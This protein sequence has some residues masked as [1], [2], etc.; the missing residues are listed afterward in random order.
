M[1]P[2]STLHVVKG[3]SATCSGS[4]DT[5][6]E[7]CSR[8][9]PED[10]IWN[11][12]VQILLALHHCHFPGARAHLSE[13]NSPPLDPSAPP[14]QPKQVL[15]RD[16]KPE[17]VF[18]STENDIKLGDFGLS[19]AIAATTFASTYVGVGRPPIRFRRHPHHTISVDP[20]LHVT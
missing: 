6:C 13:G 7:I 11:Y 4:S 17:N 1:A 20:L 9:L 15:H 19:K 10:Q 3:A 16:L 5:K 2:S 8:P 18:L 14:A 12:F